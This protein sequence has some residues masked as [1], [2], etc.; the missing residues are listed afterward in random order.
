MVTARRIANSLALHRHSP[1]SSA[2][3][4]T[5]LRIKVTRERSAMNNI[6][7]PPDLTPHSSDANNKEHSCSSSSSTTLHSSATPV[8]PISSL[9]DGKEQISSSSSCSSMS[10]AAP[11]VRNSLSDTE[12]ENTRDDH[13]SKVD[14]SA[15]SLLVGMG[16]KRSRCR[17]ILLDANNNT[18]LAVRM[19]L[20]ENA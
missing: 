1:L 9:R 2:A 16:F 18:D 20:S 17:V 10:A 6:K 14:E 8:V 15:L 4:W 13:V 12:I 5:K 11:L 3:Q 19:I 7:H